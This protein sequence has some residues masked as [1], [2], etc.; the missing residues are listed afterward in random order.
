MG[1]VCD[2]KIRGFRPRAKPSAHADAHTHAHIRETHAHMCRRVYA[3]T[4]R[5]AHTSHT[6]TLRSVSRGL[7]L[8]AC[9]CLCAR[10]CAHVFLRVRRACVN[11]RRSCISV[12]RRASACQACIGVR[13]RASA[14]V[15]LFSVC[16]WRVSVCDGVRDVVVVCVGVMVWV[17]RA[18]VCV[19][20]ASASVGVRPCAPACVSVH[21]FGVCWADGVCCGRA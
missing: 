15:G 21:W 11:V 2:C 18:S 5:H 9:V 16:V 19:G 20:L 3:P 7:R 10:V 1:C 13:Q 12:R 6:S 8:C 4:Q 17:W 14:C